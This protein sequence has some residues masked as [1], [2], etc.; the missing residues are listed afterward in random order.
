MSNSVSIPIRISPYITMSELNEPI[1]ILKGTFELVLGKAGKGALNGSIRFRWLPCT[2]MEFE[3]VYS[4]PPVDLLKQDDIYLSIEAPRQDVSVMITS[5]QFRP[6]PHR[7]RGVFREEGTF[8]SAPEVDRV[9]FCLVNFPGFLGS[10]FSYG[11]DSAG[12]FPGRLEMASRGFLCTVDAIPEVRDLRRAANQG[13][14]FVIS[15]VGELKPVR[16]TLNPETIQSLLDWM[17]LFFGF[18]RG[19]WSG[20]IFP[21]GFT[22]DQKS[23]EQ[24]G[25]WKL[26]ETREVSTWLP[27]VAPLEL[28]KLFSGFFEKCSD[29]TWDS[30]LRTALGWHIQANSSVAAHETKI[31]IAQVVLELLAWVQIV[32]NQQLHSRR[33]FERLSAAGRIRALLHH[34]KIP[35]AVPSH[36]PELMSLQDRE[37]FDGPGVLV[38]LRNALV[39]ATENSRSLTVSLSG[40]QWWQAGQLAVQY[41]ELAVLALCGYQGKYAR[42]AWRGWKGEDETFVPW[43]VEAK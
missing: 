25:S 38:R 17:H 26:S 33:D 4:G 41:I 18:L 22:G 27:R 3:G 28:N 42:R 35:A 24:L 5:S 30:A 21:Q 40:L 20:P 14:G 23:W 13:A 31:V 36:C 19:A 15:H 43:S 12:T 9:R 1:E 29:A 6:F 10:M 32:E 7:I 2:A 8:S 37:A 16:G 11:S 39:H 34:L